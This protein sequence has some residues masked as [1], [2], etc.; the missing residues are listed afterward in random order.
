MS[1]RSTDLNLPLFTFSLLMAFIRDDF[2]TFGMPVTIILYSHSSLRLNRISSL[3]ISVTFG[4][5]CKYKN[6]DEIIRV[7]TLVQL[8]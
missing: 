1:K 2:P 8:K 4:I 5:T 6:K 7:Q 3:I